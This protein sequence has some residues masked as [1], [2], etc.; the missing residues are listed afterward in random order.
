MTIPD[1]IQNHMREGDITVFRQAARLYN[2]YILLRRTN[3]K[4]ITYIG[5]AGFTPKRLDCKFKTADRD[6]YHP[7]LDRWLM[8]GGLVVNPVQDEYFRAAFNLEGGKFEKARKIWQENQGIVELPSGSWLPGGKLYT[9]DV[10][11][12]SPRYGCI[13]FTSSSMVSAVKYIHGDYDLYAIV[14][15]D[16][17]ASNIRVSEQR[18]GQ[19]HSRGKL[20]FDVQHF[21]NKRVGTAM[22]LHGSQEKYQ[23]HSDE[24]VDVFYPDG[25]TVVCCE[26]EA[27]IGALYATDFRGRMPFEKGQKANSVHGKWEHT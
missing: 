18:L 27:A 3:P 9:V 23:G 25:E 1:G 5:K 11:P 12:E 14:P 24:P 7:G 4:S 8:V 6:F 26:D 19:P 10:N 15:A 13:L 22:I 21:I 20:F 16:N 17:P 2:A